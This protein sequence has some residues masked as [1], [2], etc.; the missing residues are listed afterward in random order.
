[1]NSPAKTT[2][3]RSLVT[4]DH[5][6]PTFEAGRGRRYEPGDRPAMLPSF[7]SWCDQYATRL[8]QRFTVARTEAG[9][10][11]ILSLCLEE[12]RTDSRL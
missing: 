11:E 7:T 9:L 2:A 10:R 6:K 12:A 1:M 8:V 5:G 3:P 4:I